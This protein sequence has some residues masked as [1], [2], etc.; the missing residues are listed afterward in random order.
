MK[1]ENTRKSSGIFLILG[2]TFLIIG[3][4]TDNTAFSWT[5]IAFVLISLLLG[6]RWLRFRK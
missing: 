2:M 6:R 4:A 3:I 1:N 5:A